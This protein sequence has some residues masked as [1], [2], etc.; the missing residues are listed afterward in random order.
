MPC[1]STGQLVRR[2]RFGAPPDVIRCTFTAT[3]S[4]TG[5]HESGDVVSIE[6]SAQQPLTP[7]REVKRDVQ[8]AMNGRRETLLHHG[9]R[10]WDITT[11][12]LYGESLEAVVEFLD[13]VEDGQ[14]F[15]FEPWRYESG[16]SLDLDFITP[17]LRIAEEISCYLSSESYSL[18]LIASEGTGGADDCY[19]I[20]FS[21]IEAP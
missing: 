19:T 8:T 17:R 10:K 20:S 7:G 18:T 5:A 11:G 21:V 14:E 15:D 4:L 12:P 6:F 9:L 3:R 1:S 16:P 2:L 13:S